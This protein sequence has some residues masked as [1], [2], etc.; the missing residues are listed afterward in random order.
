MLR[1]LLARLR[2]GEALSESV[3]DYTHAGAAI[4]VGAIEDAEVG[5]SLKP[6][7]PLSVASPLLIVLIGRTWR[8]R[9]VARGGRIV[10]AELEGEEG[11]AL[12]RIMRAR[13]PALVI[14]FPAKASQRSSE[15]G[16]PP[17]SP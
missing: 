13:G 2:R 11:D 3:H 8:G 4:Y 6:L 5:E 9:I 1:R 12:R 14:A 10:A 15:S 17:S 16:G 7:L